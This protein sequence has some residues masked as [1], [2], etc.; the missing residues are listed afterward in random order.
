[1]DEIN[2]VQQ[3]WHCSCKRAKVVCQRLQQG[4]QFQLNALAQLKGSQ[5]VM[6]SGNA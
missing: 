2:A 4:T 1:M 6:M 3:R 5:R